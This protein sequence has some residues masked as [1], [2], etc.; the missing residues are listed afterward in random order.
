MKKTSMEA[1]SNPR[2]GGIIAL[3]LQDGDELINAVVTDGDQE[4]LIATRYGM[5]VRFHEEDV[6]S[7]GRTA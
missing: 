7:M 5:A 1:Y 3:G 2:R 4:L 6:R